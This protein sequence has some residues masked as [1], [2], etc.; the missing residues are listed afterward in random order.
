MA[1]KQFFLPYQAATINAVAEP[2]AKLTFYQTGTTTKLPIYTTALLDTELANPITANAAGRFADIYLDDD[3]TYRLTIADRNG[4]VLDDFD[5]FM[6]GTV[7]GFPSDTNFQFTPQMFGAVGDGVTDDYAA[8]AAAIAELPE[9]GGSLFL[10]RGYYRLSQKLILTKQIKFFGEGWSQ[11]PGTVGSTSYTGADLYTGSIIVCDAGVGGIQFVGFTDNASNATAYEYQSSTGSILQDVML[12]SLGGSGTTAH[13]VESFI[14]LNASNVRIEGFPGYGLRIAGDGSGTA[15]QYGNTSLTSLRSVSC[16]YNKLAGFSISGGNSAVIHSIGCD[17]ANNGGVGFLDA[18]P[19]GGLYLACHAS[20]NN[21]SYGTPAGYSAGQRTK[22]TT[23]WAGL[24]DQNAGSYVSTDAQGYTPYIGC[25]VE[26]DVG[27]KAELTVAA[28]VI[29]GLLATNTA[30]T[31]S[32]VAPRW[33]SSAFKNVG[34]I[35]SGANGIVEI[36]KGM[37]DIT[38]SNGGFVAPSTGLRLQYDANTGAAI[39]GT[40]ATYDFGIRNAAGSSVMLVGHNSQTASFLGNVDVASGKVLSV[41]GTQVVSARQTGTAAVAT[42][43]ATTMALVNDL[44]AKLVTHGLI[45]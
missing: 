23:D 7:I 30:H 33:N 34:Q 43:P 45:S 4:T 24:S 13:G 32:S 3:Q 40:G 9:R 14:V 10:P 42:D 22:N 12:Y 8:F 28:I 16:R 41:N 37:V 39:S 18:S 27:Y 15:N 44:R 17:S 35:Y 29:G 11:N 20:G 31:T 5:P 26:F 36:A 2:G 25:Y 38:E 21:A 6:P 1:A 19:F